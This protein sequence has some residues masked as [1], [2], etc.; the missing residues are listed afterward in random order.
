MGMRI[1]Q[2]MWGRLFRLSPG[3]CL[4]LQAQIRQML[5]SAIM[6]QHLTPGSP[7]ERIRRW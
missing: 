7:V 1:D 6:E 3:G 4:P 2:A 5:V